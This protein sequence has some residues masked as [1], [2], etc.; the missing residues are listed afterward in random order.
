MG[1]YHGE[2]NHQKVKVISNLFQFLFLVNNAVYHNVQVDT[3]PLS[4]NKKVVM[5]ECFKTQGSL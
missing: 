3:P 1:D 2:V 4:D 5:Q